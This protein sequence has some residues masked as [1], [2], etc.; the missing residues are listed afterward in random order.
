MSKTI[1]EYEKYLCNKETIKKTIDEYGVAICPILDKNECKEM[2][3]NK[4][5]ILEYLTSNLEKPI[6]RNDKTSYSEIKELFPNHKM[7][8]QN[9]EI[10]HS[11]LVWEVRQNLK[12]KEVFSKIWNTEDL[13]VSFDGVSIYILD[14]PK[15]EQN[16]WF[17]VDQ[18]YT[19]NN[20]E[21]IQSW[22]NA[23]DTNIGDATLVVLE[24]SHKYHE[25]FKNEFNI[26]DKK[27][28][29]KL[30]NKEQYDFYI[31][32]NCIEKKIMCPAGYGVFWDSRTVHYGS[33]VSKESSENYNYRCAVYICMTPRN[34]ASIKDLEKRKKYFNELRMTTHWPH[35]VKLFPK[36]PR[37]YG[38]EIKNIKKLKIEE[39]KKYI[40]EEG[41]KLI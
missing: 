5:E 20:F 27:D 14:K 34:K 2:I 38:K 18:S 33:P 8:I 4:W 16:S 28:W 31:N 30:E 13:I 40:S 35:K 15:R 25:K 3:N 11:K 23:Y 24:N 41:F 7:L 36:N 29:F 21:C 26:T 12:V 1:Y 10:G 9:W 37:T 19:R 6:N 39:V 22:I 32:N 17:H